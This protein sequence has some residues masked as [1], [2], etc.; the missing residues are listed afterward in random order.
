MHVF[1]YGTLMYEAVAARVVSGRYRQKPG[2]L[3]GYRRCPLQ[4]EDYPAI[5]SEEGMSV[6]GIIWLDVNEEDLVRL[7]AFEGDEYDRVQVIVEGENGVRV[8]AHVYRLR[9]EMR[10]KVIGGE[11]DRELFERAGLRRFQERYGGFQA[12]SD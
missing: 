10:H 4:G 12:L 2:T 9:D 8:E 3:R 11:W 1:V 5:I 6:P 7:D